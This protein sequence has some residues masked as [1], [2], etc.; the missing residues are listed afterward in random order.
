MNIR[1][2]GATALGCSSV[3]KKTPHKAATRTRT[4]EI[5]HLRNITAA[6]FSSRFQAQTVAKVDDADLT[7]DL[8]GTHNIRNFTV[9]VH[10][11][12]QLSQ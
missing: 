7:L 5:K 11:T 6:D 10:E 9:K 2:G 12:I 4:F 1:G 8:L 3:S